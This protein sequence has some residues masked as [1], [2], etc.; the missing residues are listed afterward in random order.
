MSE[1]H[2]ELSS[3]FLHY[4]QTVWGHTDFRDAGTQH[5]MARVPPND[6]LFPL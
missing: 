3:L 4:L 1:A 2:S 6:S 5:Q